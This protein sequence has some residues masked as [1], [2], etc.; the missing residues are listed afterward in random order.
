MAKLI[1]ENTKE[2]F[3]IPD[4][5]NIT[6]IC[7]KVGISFACDGEGICGS[8]IVEVVDGMNNL[9]SFTQAE[10]DFFGEEQTKRLA[11]QCVIKSGS[12]TLKF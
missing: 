2:E 10:E 6:E 9:S 8:C 4:G 7:K 3:D 11:C 12:V 5:T 1:F